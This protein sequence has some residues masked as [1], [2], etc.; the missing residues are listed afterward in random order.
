M[1]IRMK[2]IGIFHAKSKQISRLDIN[3]HIKEQGRVCF[4]LILSSM[5]NFLI[6]RHRLVLGM[7]RMPAALT[8]L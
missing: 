8:L 2:S 6:F 4:Y 3:P 7:P 1:T 5:P